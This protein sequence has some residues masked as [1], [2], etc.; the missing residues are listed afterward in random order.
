MENYSP[1]LQPKRNSFVQLQLS[2]AKLELRLG[3]VPITVL[4]RDYRNVNFLNA[5]LGGLNAKQEFME[6]WL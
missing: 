6:I 5:Y 1:R 2:G 4:Y 3:L